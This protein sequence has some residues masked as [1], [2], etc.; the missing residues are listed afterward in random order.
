MRGINGHIRSFFLAPSQHSPTGL[1][2]PD[3]TTGHMVMWN[4]TTSEQTYH[5][6][7]NDVT[8]YLIFL[9]FSEKRLKL[10]N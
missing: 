10:N 4:V 6:W 1:K 7:E 5:R 3:T 9:N 8:S 2:V